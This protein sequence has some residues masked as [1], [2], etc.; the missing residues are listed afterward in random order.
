MK[1][2][3]PYIKIHGPDS[4]VN[5]ALASIVAHAL[6]MV[7]VKTVG[8]VGLAT[9]DTHLVWD[10]LATSPVVITSVGGKKGTRPESAAPRGLRPTWVPPADVD[11]TDSMKVLAG[12]YGVSKSTI[13]KYRQLA[14]H[15]LKNTGRPRGSFKIP[16]TADLTLPVPLLARLYKCSVETARKA[17]A[18][19][20]K[21][22]QHG[23]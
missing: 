16:A 4:R 9:Q 19:A 17:K 11:W 12:R 10:I 20:A 3:T 23:D 2:R 22:A 13:A 18:R 1:D 15:E 21:E 5:N 7:D 6:Q 8:P 14:G